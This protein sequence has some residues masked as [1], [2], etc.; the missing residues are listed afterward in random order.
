MTR[1][2]KI[3][4]FINLAMIIGLI[5]VLVS[6]IGIQLQENKVLKERMLYQEMIL[7]TTARKYEYKIRIE[8]LELLRCN[9]VSEGRIDSIRFLIENANQFFKMRDS[10]Y[11]SI[12]YQNLN[13]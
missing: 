11:I 4:R 12:Q 2:Q 13:K 1:R 9:G 5:F 10:V 8:R 7:L 6:H 3:W